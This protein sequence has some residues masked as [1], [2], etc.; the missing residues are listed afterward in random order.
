ML[1]QVQFKPRNRFSTGFS[2]ELVIKQARVAKHDPPA[3]AD[4]VAVQ[5]VKFL[6]AVRDVILEGCWEF[7]ALGIDIWQIKD[8]CVAVLYN[9]ISLRLR[10]L[11]QAN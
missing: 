11:C 3:A 8:I 2:M 1:L 4:Q 9:Y 10:V 7:Q 5:S 6:Y